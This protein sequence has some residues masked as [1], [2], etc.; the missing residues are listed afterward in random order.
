MQSDSNPWILIR[1]IM[2]LVCIFLLW[3]I[4][5]FPSRFPGCT[6][7]PGVYLLQQGVGSPSSHS[8][9]LFSAICPKYQDRSPPKIFYRLFPS[10][11]LKQRRCSP[12]LIINARENQ[13][14]MNFNCLIY[15]KADFYA[16]LPYSYTWLP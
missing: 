2:T 10:G 11:L 6:L 7:A 16:D 9:D 3:V 12:H 14:Y 1:L 5:S 4:F 13:M 8:P 15:F